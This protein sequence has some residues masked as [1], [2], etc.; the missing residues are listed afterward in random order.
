MKYNVLIMGDRELVQSFLDKIINNNLNNEYNLNDEYHFEYMVLEEIS[1]HI[2]DKT[3]PLY[4]RF[5]DIK[6]FNY[7]V[8]M[9]DLSVEL[10]IYDVYKYYIPFAVS[11]INRQCPNKVKR[12]ST[13]KILIIANDTTIMYPIFQNYKDID[14]VIKKLY[15][16]YDTLY[17]IT[18]ITLK[19]D[20]N[21]EQN[22]LDIHLLEKFGKFQYTIISKSNNFNKYYIN[23]TCENFDTRK[24]KCNIVD[25]M[26]HDY[27][28]KDGIYILYPY[29]NNGKIIYTSSVPDRTECTK[30]QFKL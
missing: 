29:N 3:L 11:M 10:D 16:L 6:L 25:G 17:N 13:N 19:I 7:F 9:I 5:S 26:A 15:K 30:F 20:N 18:F 22:I 12:F 28:K 1:T 4:T 14:I 24:F 23:G 21:I 2:C 8:I 27:Y